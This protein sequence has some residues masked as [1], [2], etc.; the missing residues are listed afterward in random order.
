MLGGCDLAH[1]TLHYVCTIV[2][3]KLSLLGC[4]P[5]FRFF[6]ADRNHRATPLPAH[7]I[8]I[9]V[10]TLDPMSV[11]DLVLRATILMGFTCFLRPNSFHELRWRDLTFDASLDEA[12][13]LHLE[14]VVSV[15]DLKMVAFA[16]AIG[17]VSRKVKLCEFAPRELCVVRTLVALGVKLGVFDLD[18]KGACGQ[19]RFVVRSE[20][21]EW[22]VFPAVEGGLLTPTKTVSV[23]GGCEGMVP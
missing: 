22:F 19:R 10:Q 13:D 9:L 6:G 15:P 17:G 18:L 1:Q 8:R 16:A 11:P 4:A 2:D 5:F 14:V 12:G 20:C 23:C 3:I 21:T 7:A